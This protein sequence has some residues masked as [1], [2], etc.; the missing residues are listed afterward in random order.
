LGHAP[1][2]AAGASAVAKR[3]AT[4]L[5]KVVSSSWRRQKFRGHGP[6]GGRMSGGDNSA[7]S[8]ST[9]RRQRPVRVVT[10]SRRRVTSTSWTLAPRM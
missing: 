3:S 8:A 5:S 2:H 10:L 6:A 4:T 9:D 7:R 1:L